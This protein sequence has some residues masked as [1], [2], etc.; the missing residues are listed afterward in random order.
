MTPTRVYE[1]ARLKLVAPNWQSHPHPVK[2]RT[3]RD[4]QRREALAALPLP[5][6]E[7]GAMFDMLDAELSKQSCDHTR[8]LTR[9]WL[10]TRGHNVDVVF[11]WLD[12]HRVF[13]DCEVLVNSEEDVA[14]AKRASVRPA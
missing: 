14:E 7:L 3:P 2:V 1:A 8:R 13:C 5:V 11:A 6:V 12:D 9:R 4:Q 10:E